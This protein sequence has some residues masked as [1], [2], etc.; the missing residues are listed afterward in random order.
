MQIGQLMGNLTDQL[1]TR[2]PLSAT[3]IHQFTTAVA[4][5]FNNLTD[6]D[7]NLRIKT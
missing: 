7:C 2:N 3:Q 4:E 6:K 1:V 5:M